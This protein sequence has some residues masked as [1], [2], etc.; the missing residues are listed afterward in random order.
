MNYSFQLGVVGYGNMAEAIVGG[1]LKSGLNEGRDIM[2]YDVSESRLE[3]AESVG[4]TVSKNMAELCSS[5]RYILLSVKPQVFGEIAGEIGKSMEQNIVISIMAGVTVEKL[6]KYLPKARICRCMPNTPALIGCGITAVDA[7]R[8]DEAE[9][10]YVFDIFNSVGKAL[11]I[12]EE[13]M[14]AVTA[15]SGSGPAYAYLFIKSMVEAGVK[16]GLSEE[17]SKELAVNTVIG[18]SRMVEKSGEPINNLID[19]VCSKGGTT[20]Q[21]INVLKERGL[22]E[23]VDECVKA[24]YLRAEE[25]SKL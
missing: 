3:K 6:S 20:I 2:V 21:G 11:E 12:G 1:I 18:A 7:S 17:Q 13:L 25:L 22:P 14:N 9:R 15:V 24:A 23:I 10:K 8:L 16:L 5:C 19:R 4:L